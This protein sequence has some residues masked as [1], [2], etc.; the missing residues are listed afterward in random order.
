MKNVCFMYIQCGYF[1]N[2]IIAWW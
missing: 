2:L 1:N